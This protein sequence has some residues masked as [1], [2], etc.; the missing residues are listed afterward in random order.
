MP[1][2]TALAI[3]GVLVFFG[4]EL[5]LRGGEAQ[6]A[7]WSSD[8]GDRGSTRLIL[9][10]YAAVIV[11]N[12]A[13]GGASVAAVAP[14]WRW[15]GLVCMAGGLAVRA[16]AMSTLGRHYTR[17]LRTLDE[18]QLV[19]RGPYRLVRH[20]GYSGSILVWIG[21]ALALGNWIATAITAVLLA[22]VYIWRMNAEEALLRRSF[23][24]RYADYQ[25]HTKRLLP[26]VY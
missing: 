23:G 16:W 18:Q 17:T 15:V 7:T 19:D 3:C 25:L 14:L 13:L 11:V 24:D 12:I 21:Y 9:G 8:D 6:T 2:T 10:A 1:A 26:F 22:A 4:Y 20:P 5:V